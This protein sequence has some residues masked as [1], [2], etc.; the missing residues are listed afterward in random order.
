MLILKFIYNWSPLALLQFTIVRIIIKS[1]T[2]ITKLTAN[3]S[4]GVDS[5]L[6]VVH[7]TLRNVTESTINY[8]VTRLPD[9]TSRNTT[10]QRHRIIKP[11]RRGGQLNLGSITLLT[12]SA[13]T[14]I[15]AFPTPL[16]PQ[17]NPMQLDAESRILGIDNRASRCISRHRGDFFGELKPSTLIIHWYAGRT[18]KS[19]HIGTIRW[20]WMDNVRRTHEFLIPNSIHDPSGHNLLSPQHWAKH[21]GD[22]RD[23]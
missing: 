23:T 20:K 9:T 19:L 10:S 12:H 5:A 15:N 21:T 2:L 18:T 13:M 22:G 4:N 1:W 17:M 7:Q 8:L 3:I 16:S 11:S 6:T 14:S